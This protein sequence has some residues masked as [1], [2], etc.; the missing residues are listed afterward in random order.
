MTIYVRKCTDAFS[1]GRWSLMK[2]NELTLAQ[3]I[4]RNNKKFVRLFVRHT[5][6]QKCKWTWERLQ[7]WL[8]WYNTQ[9]LVLS[10]Y[11]NLRYSRQILWKRNIKS[12]GSAWKTPAKKQKQK[13]K[14][15]LENKKK[16]KAIP[17]NSRLT[18]T[19]LLEM[20]WLTRINMPT[21]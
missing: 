13:Q 10:D 12:D 7:C 4:A 5:D 15:Q 3:K 21:N 14:H 16:W 2:F 19:F 20:L 11:G 18:E 17:W 1:N 9:F 8:N 6:V